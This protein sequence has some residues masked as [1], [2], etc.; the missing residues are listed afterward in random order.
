MHVCIFF[1]F[2]GIH[3]QSGAPINDIRLDVP[4]LGGNGSR[5]NVKEIVGS[6][7]SLFKVPFIKIWVERVFIVVVPD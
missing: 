4:E 7:M 3:I 6:G 2:L 1:F 5:S